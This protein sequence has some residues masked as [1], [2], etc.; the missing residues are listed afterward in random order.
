M[1][2]R[3]DQID[4]RV[5]DIE[6]KFKDIEPSRE[7]DSSDIEEINKK[8]SECDAL[9]ANRR[10]IEEQQKTLNTEVRHDITDIRSRSMRDILLF[11]GIPE[12]R[13]SEN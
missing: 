3:L 6:V 4:K 13:A 10:Q 2:V 5:N 7:Y 9:K 11:F 8:H 12:V 1:K